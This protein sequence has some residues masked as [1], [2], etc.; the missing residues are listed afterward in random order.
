MIFENGVIA[1][2]SHTAACIYVCVCKIIMC[3]RTRTFELLPHRLVQCCC[4][5]QSEKKC[6]CDAFPEFDGG[7]R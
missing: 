1:M 4:S 5:L 7:V 6:V 3:S 2:T